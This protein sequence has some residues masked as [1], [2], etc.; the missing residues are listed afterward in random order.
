MEAELIL[1]YVTMLGMMTN[2]P[3]NLAHYHGCL[4]RTAPIVWPIM[5]VSY[6]PENRHNGQI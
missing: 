2:D 6:D 1:Q 5:R 4:R 3:L